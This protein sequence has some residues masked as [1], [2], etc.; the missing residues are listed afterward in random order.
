ME[1]REKLSGKGRH[2]EHDP[3]KA[4]YMLI[5]AVRIAGAFLVMLGLMGINGALP[6]P[7]IASYALIAIGLID[8]FVLPIFLSKRWSSRNQ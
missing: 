3:A 4:K 6:L 5:S 8:V 7:D 1:E 2:G